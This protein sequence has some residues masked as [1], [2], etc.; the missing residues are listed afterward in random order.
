VLAVLRGQAVPLLA[1]PTHRPLEHHHRRQG[2]L[3]RIVHDLDTTRV[4]LELGHR[5][6]CDAR[7]GFD[8]DA[9][10]NE[11]DHRPITA[12][13]PMVGVRVDPQQRALDPDVVASCHGHASLEFVHHPLPGSPRAGKLMYIEGIINE[14]A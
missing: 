7:G 8:G 12:V 9:L 2:L 14:A 4:S 1:C 5:R 13:D 6:A 10:S 3:A 11:V